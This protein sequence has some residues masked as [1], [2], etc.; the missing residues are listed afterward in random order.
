MIISKVPKDIDTFSV[1][2]PN[3]VVKH[4]TNKQM[5]ELFVTTIP[6][7]YTES[8][9]KHWEKTRRICKDKVCCEFMLKYE[10]NIID[11][12]K[13]GYHYRLAISTGKSESIDD[14]TKELYC[15]IVACTNDNTKSCGS[16]YRPSDNVVSSVSFNQISVRMTIEIENSE[17]D[18]LIMPTNV[19]FLI[20]PLKTTDFD[21]DKSSIFTL[22]E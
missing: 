21:Y 18:Y 7:D 15:A 1:Q 16:R 9:P 3:N 17:D 5:D 22:Q 14:K 8:L 2:V 4:F 20:L 13:L 11:K 6:L 12:S 19:D 10:K